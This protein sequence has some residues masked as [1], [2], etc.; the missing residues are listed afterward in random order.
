MCAL[1]MK[2]TNYGRPYE[3]TYVND[4]YLDSVR[5]QPKAVPGIFLPNSQ[6]S[7]WPITRISLRG[8]NSNSAVAQVCVSDPLQSLESAYVGASIRAPCMTCMRASKTHISI[9]LHHYYSTT[10]SHSSRA[11]RWRRSRE[12][13]ERERH[14]TPCVHVVQSRY[15]Q[16]ET[17][18]LGLGVRCRA[19]DHTN[20]KDKRR[21]KDVTRLP[22]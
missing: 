8:K 19:A 16:D 5:G 6:I 10:V 22:R 13:R 14:Q 15:R 20:D 17:W 18:D 12:E 4:R 11:G 7:N 9:V 21:R 3:T 1:S 2:H